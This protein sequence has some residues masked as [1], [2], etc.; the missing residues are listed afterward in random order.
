MQV[1]LLVY[2]LQQ[3]MS[4]KSV[5]PM[6]AEEARNPSVSEWEL[7]SIFDQCVRIAADRRSAGSVVYILQG[8]MFFPKKRN[9]C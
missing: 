5:H 6:A 3:T 8:M 7:R 2:A 9:I 4:F 1:S